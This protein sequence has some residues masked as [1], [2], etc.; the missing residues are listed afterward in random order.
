VI[1]VAANSIFHPVLQPG[2][3]CCISVLPYCTYQPYLTKPQSYLTVPQ[4]L[5]IAAEIQMA[6]T[7]REI[8]QKKKGS[9]NFSAL[10]LLVGQQEGHLE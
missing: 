8:T 6:S 10:T 2:I 4:P 5:F 1:D 3:T 9:V 7:G